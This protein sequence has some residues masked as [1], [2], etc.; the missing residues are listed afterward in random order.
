MNRVG[1]FDYIQ[2]RLATLS[3]RIVTS[4]KLNLQ[5]LNV[6]S[7]TFFADLLNQIFDWKLANLNT[8][9][10]NV[11]GIDLVDEGNMLL[12]QVSSTCTKQKIENSL[13]KELLKSYNGYTFKFIS[14]AKDASALRK[15]SY[16]NPSPLIFAPQTDVIDLST[17][18]FKVK[19]MDITKQKQLYDFI[20]A[21]LGSGTDL[22]KLDSN[23][24][25]IINILSK[26]NL[27]E[28]IDPPELN[29]FGIENKIDLNNLSGVRETIN[30]YKVYFTK[31]SNI[32]YAFD[33][34]GYNKSFSVLQIIR[35]QYLKRQNTAMSPSDIFYSTI[36][37][38]MAIVSESKNYV[39]IP[40][41]ELELCVNI[42]V[43]DAFIRC[44]IFKNPEGYNYAITG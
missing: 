3:T 37:D 32:Y 23:L 19:A 26:E 42:L 35:K 6:H 34:E 4:G 8:D 10:P 33:K 12:A 11:E 25:N 27:N 28:Y 38:V 16:Q 5:D 9:Q 31:V 43:V 36:T 14:I 29:A 7:E 1:Y 20:R 22:I 41:D 18:F 15:Q 40:Y 13:E 21:E 30:D 17:L 24:A 39:E 2:E 44:K